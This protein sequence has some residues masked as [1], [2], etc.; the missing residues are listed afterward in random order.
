MLFFA[1]SILVSAFLLFLVEPL[2][3]RIIL[4]WFGGSATVWTTCL[5]FFQ[6]MLL[7]GYLYAHT[8]SRFLRPRTQAVVHI[9]LLAATL[10]ALPILPPATWK[11]AD[12]FHPTERIISLLA[13]TVGGPFLL[14]ATTGPLL[15]AWYARQYPGRSPY[16]LY[17]LSNAGSLL[18]L[19]AYPTIVEPVIRLRAQAYLWSAAYGVFL[20]L[21]GI[22]AWRVFRSSNEGPALDA[23]PVETGCNRPRTAD[24]LLWIGLAFCPS[25]LL[26]A[27]TSH[28][29]QNIAPIPLLW[30]A[31]LALYLLSFVITFDRGRWYSRK[32]WFPMF[33]AA[34][35]I[36]LAL[37]FP[38]GRNLGVKVV[39]PVFGAA[40][41]CC[42]VA[43][44]GELYRARP[45]VRHLTSFYL[46]VALGGALGGVFV[47]VIAPV[48]FHDYLELPIGLLGAVLLVT[49]VLPRSEPSLPGPAARSIEF[50]LMGALAAGLVYLVAFVNPQFNSRYRLIERNF[51]GV[52][53]VEDVADTRELQHGSINHGTEFLRTGWHRVP[54]TYYGRTSGV[55]VAIQWGPPNGRRIG[56]VGLGAG[57]L[58]AYGRERDLF[59]FYDI[60]P[61]VPEIAESQFYYL[62]ECPA[63]VDIVLGDGRLSLERE[64]PQNF[65]VLAV[66]AFSSDSI[67]VH[68]LTIE[69]FQQYFRHLKPTGVL[70]MHV[71]NKYLDLAR[72]VA[73]AAAALHKPAILIANPADREEGV[74]TSDWVILA[75]NR[76][77]FAMPHWIVPYRDPLPPPL[78]KPWTDDYSGVAAVLK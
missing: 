50:G 34:A 2:I 75:N 22:V 37:M 26:L 3:A 5:M 28:M 14:L 36:M 15:Q 54:T 29:T 39:I 40:F 18:A 68:L 6:V 62:R 41:F 67:P 65:D 60:N 24:Y 21:C 44:H 66:D 47:G 32:F 46:M 33:V 72:V 45:P 27:V 35:S 4:P 19:I 8:L 57:T 1:A 20:A 38:E 7:A 73:A 42:A 9:S 23:D 48:A 55:G 51:Y 61:L 49:A 70:A 64:P 58:A 16:R 69:A 76:D 12:A 63:R 59:R 11:P 13:A 74:F 56:V 17:A 53:R 30:L 43:C 10:L 52:L 77:V 25:T 31:P 78:A 71:S